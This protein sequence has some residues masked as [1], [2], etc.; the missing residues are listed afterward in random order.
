MPSLA[1][2]P[3]TQVFKADAHYVG[4]KIDIYALKERP[5]FK[6]GLSDWACKLGGWLPRAAGC[7]PIDDGLQ[8]ARPGAWFSPGRHACP[9]GQFRARMFTQGHY[10]R[11]HK[12]GVVL[13]LSSRHISD[14]CETQVWGEE[15][16]GHHAAGAVAAAAPVAAGCSCRWGGGC[17]LLLA[18]VG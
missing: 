6:V 17:T 4:S 10:K 8:R 14:Q 13:A 15:A 11:V 3:C 2:C 9:P 12:G 16:H 18:G 5:E 7:C 1:C